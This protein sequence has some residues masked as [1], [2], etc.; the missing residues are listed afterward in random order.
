VSEPIA[1]RP[2]DPADWQAFREIRLSAL[3][4]E[5]G[6]FFSSYLAELALEPPEWQARIAGPGRVVFGL[7]AGDD[8]IGITGVVTDRDDPTGTTAMLAMSYIRPDYR[9]RRLTALFYEARLRWIAAQPHFTRAIVSHRASNTAS[10]RAILRAGFTRIGH[11]ART[12]PDGT[13]E[14]EVRYEFS[15]RAR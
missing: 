7:F 11:G 9:G 15:L 3:Q 13:T 12:W 5:P 4:T 14:D 2:L 6:V 10:A 1:I 8:L